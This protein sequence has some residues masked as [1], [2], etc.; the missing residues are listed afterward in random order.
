MSGL[1][2]YIGGKFRLSQKICDM[3]DYSLPCYVELFGGG[4]NVLF[5][6]KP[7]QVEIWNDANEDLFLLYQTVQEFPKEFFRKLKYV[8]YS[9]QLYQEIVQRWS[10]GRKPESKIDRA[11]ETFLLHQWAFSGNP[12][13]GWAFGFNANSSRAYFSKIKNLIQYHKRLQNVQ[14]E[15]SDFRI[16][17][18]SI[19]DNKAKCSI[20]ADPPYFD[21]EH[22]YSHPFTK[23]DHIALAQM[24]NELKDFCQIIVSYYP[25]PDIQNL[26][27][28][29][30]IIE[31]QSFK[32]S[33]K[34]SPDKPNRPKST[35]LLIYNYIPSTQ[36]TLFE[37][38]EI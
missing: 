3:L 20:Y 32:S 5:N 26:Y 7:H 37:K 30:K 17:L 2:R 34:T 1:V 36:P 12:F 13:T 24:L 15:N 16:I 11:F 28:D 27:S 38:E 19:K 33:A 35:E 4:G 10:E 31:I 22:Y 18:Q 23:E 6:K 14:V 29:W 25:Y 8:I 21:A 9:R